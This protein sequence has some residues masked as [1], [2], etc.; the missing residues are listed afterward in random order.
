MSDESKSIIPE[1]YRGKR[2]A[3]WLATFV[4][5]EV[6]VAVMKTVKAKDKEGNV[7]GEKQVPS[8]KTSVDLDRLF[9]LCHQ[10]GID[11]AK[12]EEQRERP[13]APGR[14]RMTLGNS[15]R[16]AARKRHGLYNLEAEWVEAPADFIG[17]LPL[18]E[19]PDGTGIAKAAEPVAAE[20]VEDEEAA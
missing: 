10:N 16:A 6:K 1:K 15:L 8:A 20:P 7:T 5:G 3:D 4:D 2:D 12:M 17:D 19:N 14:I 18:K 13:N 11:T 9:K